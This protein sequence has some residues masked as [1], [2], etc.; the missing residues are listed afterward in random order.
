M[1]ATSTPVRSTTIKKKQ[2]T[3]SEDLSVL[4]KKR[5][6]SESSKSDI[7]DIPNLCIMADQDVQAYVEPTAIDISPAGT[8]SQK[9]ITLKDADI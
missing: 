7:S 4:K 2:L 1:Y 6:L 9:V 3:S 5:L 8:S